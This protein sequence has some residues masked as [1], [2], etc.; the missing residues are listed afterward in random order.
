MF[1]IRSSKTILHPL[2]SAQHPRKLTFMNYINW[3]P[4]PSGFKLGSV[5]EKQQRGSLQVPITT[6]SL[7]PCWPKDGATSLSLLVP[8]CYIIP[9]WDS[10]TLFV[11]SSPF[12]TFYF[13]YGECYLFTIW[14]LTDR[15]GYLTQPREICEDFSED[16]MIQLC[17][18]S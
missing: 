4:L 5:N 17:L 2:S 7:C 14:T 12:M 18:N 6:G 9:C 15:E 8:R 10:L 16:I 13:T 3:T 1:S 11:V